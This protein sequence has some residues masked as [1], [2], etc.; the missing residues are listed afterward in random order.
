MYSQSYNNSHYINMCQS[1]PE[2]IKNTYFCVSFNN[3]LWQCWRALFFSS[4]SSEK[5]A[6]IIEIRHRPV[7]K[8]HTHTHSHLR[9][10][11][12]CSKHKHHATNTTFF[13]YY[14]IE[15]EIKKKQQENTYIYIHTRTTYIHNTHTYIHT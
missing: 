11:R 13:T 10:T 1:Q 6:H 7:Y 2:T 4:F 15:K 3:V 9:Y 12:M 5:Q 8:S 14:F